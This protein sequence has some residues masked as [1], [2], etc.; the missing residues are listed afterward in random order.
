MVDVASNQYWLYRRRMLQQ[1]G[2]NVHVY[3][4]LIVTINSVLSKMYWPDHFQFVNSLN[5]YKK[6]INEKKE[7]NKIT[8]QK[9]KMYNLLHY[10][11]YVRNGCNR[12]MPVNSINLSQLLQLVYDN[13]IVTC[14][15]LLYTFII[16][17]SWWFFTCPF[18]YW[19][20]Q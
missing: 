9:W 11:R 12:L 13:L 6:E 1:H 19:R 14:R 3:Q 7:K 4:L 5:R 10:S 2:P 18:S 16:A 15:R 8:R 20:R 17:I